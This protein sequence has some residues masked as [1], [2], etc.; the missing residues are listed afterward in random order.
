MP[1]VVGVPSMFVSPSMRISAEPV[2]SAI[3][4][5]PVAPLAGNEPLV[6]VTPSTRIS[7]PSTASPAPP[8]AS[9][10]KVISCGAGGVAEPVGVDARQ[11]QLGEA[12]ELRDRPDR[13]NAWCR[14]PNDPKLVVLAKI[15]MPPVASWM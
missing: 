5:L 10:D 9:C 1:A 11:L 15:S 8:S 6:I 14:S 2:A 7:R 13:L 12:V 3:V 4:T